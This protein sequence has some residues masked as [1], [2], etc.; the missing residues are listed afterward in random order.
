MKCD[1]DPI[2]CQPCRSK[3]LRCFTTDRVTGHARERGQSD[4]TE[5]ELMYMQNQLQ[6]YRQK[7]GPLGQDARPPPSYPPTELATSSTFYIPSSRYVGWPAP[8]D[9]E[10]IERG[11]VYGTRVNILDG[12]MDVADFEC[13]QMRM[14]APGEYNVFNASRPSILSSIF[15]FQ[16][17]AQPDFPSKDEAL[18][19]AD[20]FLIIMSQYVPIVHRS[21]FKSLV[22]I[23]TYLRVA[24]D[25]A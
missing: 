9:T 20:Q 10:S 2:A 6:M 7:Y 12:M 13:D 25:S 17:V 16:S 18:Q 3:Q 24:T 19:S 5:N 11:P 23:S 14:P 1:T 8:H 21:S 22:S 15:H 4:R